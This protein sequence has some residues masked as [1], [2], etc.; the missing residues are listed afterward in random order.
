MTTLGV[1][2]PVYLLIIPS[3][4]PFTPLCQL[5]QPGSNFWRGGSRCPHRVLASGPFE[6]DGSHLPHPSSIN[7]FSRPNDYFNLPS[8][9]FLSLPFPHFPIIRIQLRQYVAALISFFR[10]VDD[11]STGSGYIPFLCTVS[12]GTFFEPLLYELSQLNPSLFYDLAKPSD[13]P[14]PI[15]QVDS[16]S[17]SPRFPAVSVSGA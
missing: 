14:Y 16:T 2:L 10:R 3:P 12:F 15:F 11:C 9:E 8:I 13:E 5:C 17:P 6:N 4:P 7:L 1:P